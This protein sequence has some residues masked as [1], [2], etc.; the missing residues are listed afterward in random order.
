MRIFLFW[1]EPD[2]NDF[3]IEMEKASHKV[4][5]CVAFGERE[6]YKSASF[7]FHHHEDAIDNIPPA[8]INLADFPPPG[9]NLIRQFYRTESTV[10]TMM[11]KHYDNLNVNERKHLYYNMLQYWYGIIDKL[12]P[13]YII[14]PTIPHS[15]YNYIIYDIAKFLEIKTIIFDEMVIS[16][17]M[18]YYYD[19]WQT[20][21]VLD[22]VIEKNRGKNFLVNDLS[23]DIKKY[24]LEQTD[25]RQ[26]ATPV[27]IK[28]DKKNYSGIGKIRL[29][30]KIIFS[31]IKDFS[32]FIKVPI[33]L[34]K[35][36]NENIKREYKAWQKEVD[37]T[38][39]FIYFPLQYQPEGSSNPIADMF[40]DQILIAE[41]L[42]ASLPK[43]WYLYVKEH[44][45]QFLMRGINYHGPRYRGY[46]KKIA[47]L[48]N[49]RL[50][51]IE[52]NTFSLIN[53]AQA[54]ATAAGT[55][56]LE[57]VFRKKPA[58]IFGY[59][60]YRGCPGLFK[61]NDVESCRQAINKIL[62][63]FKVDQQQIINFLKSFD[64]ASFHAYIEKGFAS[65]SR[66]KPSECLTDVKKIILKDIN[67][68]ID[69]L[70]NKY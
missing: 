4:V 63:G 55:A 57:A 43:D 25:E 60:R 21:K 24:Y 8:G 36:F 68:T 32:I 9:D 27:Y 35:L 64:E 58:I 12:K 54:V 2:F 19:F 11:D 52:T 5:Y 41:I 31:S 47:T 26:D 22:R 3:I 65:I 69:N 13:E 39:K 6:K 29:K 59:P 44:P 20:S 53:S 34:Y 17:R 37:W 15:V 28:Q 14:F 56:G 51:P 42:S 10:L 38:K 33:F 66:L 7:I 61:V 48:K 49:V 16:D 18:L 45:T 23:Y 67:Y 1:P 62:A 70:I 46:Y 30:T 40:T 50:V